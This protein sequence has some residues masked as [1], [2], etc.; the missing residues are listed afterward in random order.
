MTDLYP[1]PP[2]V[3]LF[4]ATELGQS[5]ALLA[6][7]DVL[8]KA[9]CIFSGNVLVAHDRECFRDVSDVE[10]EVIRHGGAPRDLLVRRQVLRLQFRHLSMGFVTLGLSSAFALGEPHPLEVAIHAGPLSIPAHI[11]SRAD[12]QAAK[13]I[14]GW[15]ER[16]LLAL[17]EPVHAEYGA[18]GIEAKFPTPAALNEVGRSALRPTTWFWSS[19]V[20]ARTRA[21]GES[22]L[23]SLD[24]SAVTQSSEGTLFR[25]WRPWVE[26]QIDDHS[27]DRVVSFLGH[28]LGS[29]R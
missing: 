24:S 3:S 21:Y 15:L 13:R 2:H 16:L 22:L 27:L 5:E 11:W 12:R 29:P 6:A 20:G 4:V 7:W 23:S 25:A 9:G 1:E 10:R 26:P 14:M 8:T 18:I 19:Q 17:A 28:T